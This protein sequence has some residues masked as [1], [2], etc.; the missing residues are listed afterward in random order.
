MLWSRWESINFELF[1]IEFI[2]VKW[3]HLLI[4][5][6]LNKYFLLFHLTFNQIIDLAI[7]YSNWYEQRWTKQNTIKSI[8]LVIDS[9]E[10]KP[11]TVTKWRGVAK[12]SI[13]FMHFQIDYNKQTNV[14]PISLSLSIWVLSYHNDH[15]CL[16]YLPLA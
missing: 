5:K 8:G 15:K 14:E 6:N 2:F 11:I 1:Q 9:M 16:S 7:R 13:D 3:I 4:Q 10:D 12:F